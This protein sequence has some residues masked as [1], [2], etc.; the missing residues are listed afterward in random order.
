MYSTRTCIRASYVLP[1]ARLDGTS[2]DLPSVGRLACRPESP[3]PN[4]PAVAVRCRVS[5]RPADTECC[6]LDLTS[7][8]IPT[9]QTCAVGPSTTGAD[10]GRPYGGKLR[11]VE[12]CISHPHGKIVIGLRT[13]RPTGPALQLLVSFNAIRAAYVLFR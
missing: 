5:C 4:R 7:P 10:G 6:W 3:D 12:A 13:W 2:C 9:P 8:S 11:M 1:P